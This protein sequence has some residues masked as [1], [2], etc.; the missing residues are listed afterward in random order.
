MTT[1][2]HIRTR[3]ASF[4]GISPTMGSN[5]HVFGVLTHVQ[6]AM[7]DSIVIHIVSAGIK[8]LEEV[9]Q[10]KAFE[11]HSMGLFPLLDSHCCR[12]RCHGFQRKIEKNPISV[13]TPGIGYPGAEGHALV[14]KDALGPWLGLVRWRN[15]GKMMRWHRCLDIWH[16]RIVYTSYIYICIWLHMCI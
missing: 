14:H 5:L 10:V 4:K 1:Y 15:T 9:N 13:V 3:I 2:K 7:K 12:T 8:K 16:V 6:F 11:P